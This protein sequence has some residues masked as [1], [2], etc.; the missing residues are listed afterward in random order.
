MKSDMIPIT[1]THS[2]LSQILK[3]ESFLKTVIDGKL[4]NI[5]EERSILLDVWQGSE[6]TSG[7]LHMN[8]LSS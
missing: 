5:F 2:E 7:L 3:M 4:L 1:E 6:Y 8:T